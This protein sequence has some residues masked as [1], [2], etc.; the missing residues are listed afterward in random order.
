MPGDFYSYLLEAVRKNIL[1]LTSRCNVGCVFCSHRQNPEGVQI[2]RLPPLSLA[3][4]E[5]LA[6]FLD[7]REKVVIGESATRLVEGEP[8]THPEIMP[9]LKLVRS[10]LPRT[11][12][13]ITTNATL[14]SPQLVAELERLMPLEVTVSLNSVTAAGRRLLMQDN[15]VNRAPQAVAALAQSSIPFHGSLVAMLHLTGWRDMEETVSFLAGHGALTVR[16]FLPGYT[17]KTPQDLRFPLS[18][19]EEVVAFAREGTGRFRLPVIPEPCVPQNLAATVWGVMAKTPAQAAGLQPGDVIAEVNGKAVST[20]VEAFTAARRAAN[21]A[22][23]FTRRGRLYQTRLKKTA[24][25][26]PGFVM[27]YDFSP[28]RVAAMERAIKGRQAKR[29]LV[30]ASAFGAQLVRQV[31]DKFALPDLTVCKVDNNFFGG[32]IQAAG[33]LTV[34]DFLAAARKVSAGRR[35]DLLLVPQ[36]AF[37]GRGFD[38]TGRQAGVLA[39]EL[40][41]ACEIV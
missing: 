14:L 27:L 21:P 9:I 11:T 32:S 30:L 40:C 38:L 41:V 7:P 33:L 6:Q 26:P 29:P 13:A 36:E 28:Q 23:S 39:Q 19:W 20:R 1:P 35:H 37:D 2:Y 12:I 4:V 17:A 22:I 10:L 15:E 25:E 5:E 24:M 18:L 8:F 31:A 3:K 34:Q 16:L